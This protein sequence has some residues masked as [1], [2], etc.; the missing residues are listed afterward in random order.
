MIKIKSKKLT[1]N[2]N[3]IIWRKWVIEF[4]FLIR[5]LLHHKTLKVKYRV[6]V[7]SITWLCIVK[8]GRKWPCSC[9][10]ESRKEYCHSHKTFYSNSYDQKTMSFKFS[11]NIF[12]A[13]EMPRNHCRPFWKTNNSFL[14]HPFALEVLDYIHCWLYHCKGQIKK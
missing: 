7:N 10:W 9:G 14:F 2:F 5:L 13:F 8:N 6:V 11:K 3:W 1:K 4:I 12:I